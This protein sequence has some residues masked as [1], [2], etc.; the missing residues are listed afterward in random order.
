MVLHTPISPMFWEHQ[1]TT[2]PESCIKDFEQSE[3]TAYSF[4]LCL[5]YAKNVGEFGFS[6][7]KILAT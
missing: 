3:Q 7:S 5:K 4:N 2:N 6:K 1:N